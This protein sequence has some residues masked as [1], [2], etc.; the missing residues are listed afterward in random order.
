MKLIRSS[1]PNKWS[2][3]NT[4]KEIIIH[5]WDDPAKKPTLNGVVAHFQNPAVKVAAHYVVS[6]DTVVQMCEETDRAWHARA[7]NSFGIGIEVDP[8]VPGN[9]Y[10]TL[11]ELVRGI[12]SRRGN[13]PLKPHKLYA[14][15]V[16]PGTIDLARI[17]REANNPQGEIKMITKTGMQVLYRFL[18]GKDVDDVAL[19]VYVGKKTFEEALADLKSQAAFEKRKQLA[20]EAKLDA[21]QFLPK[22]IRDV[23]VPPAG[24]EFLPIGQLYVKK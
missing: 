17:D 14:T 1:T 10:K 13:I 12:R 11:G 19:G 9:T 24:G 21:A 22:E 5:W 18:F 23:Y 15:T 7:A 6:D 16:C 4:C 2:G 20:K 3:G 8:N